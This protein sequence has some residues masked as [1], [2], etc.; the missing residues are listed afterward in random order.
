MAFIVIKINQAGEET[1]RYLD[2]NSERNTLE[3]Y[4]I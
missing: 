1:N 3:E 2:L 4:D